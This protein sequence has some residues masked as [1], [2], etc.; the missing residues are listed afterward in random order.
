MFTRPLG[1]LLTTAMR[2]IIPSMRS[3]TQNSIPIASGTTGKNRQCDH[4]ACD[5][6]GEHRAPKSRYQLKDY[7][8]FCLDHVRLY[9]RSWNFC[10]GMNEDQIEKEIRQDTVWRRP[11]WPMGSAEMDT[12]WRFLKNDILFDDLDIMNPKFDKRTKTNNIHVPE[13]ST[14]ESKAF[15]ILGLDHAAS[16]RELKTRYKELVKIHHPDRNGGDKIAEERLKDINDA[17]AILRKCVTA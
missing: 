4:P 5:L 12:R 16:L 10:A 1:C 11:T 6:P 3:G 13:P 17:Y 2:S 15:V 9:N 14:E 8:W 7:F